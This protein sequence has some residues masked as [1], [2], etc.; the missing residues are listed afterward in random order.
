M[1]GCSLI[2][3]G[4]LCKR[5]SFRTAARPWLGASMAHASTTEKASVGAECWSS[6]R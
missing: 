6:K 3:L 4:K 5:E 1:R 2:P